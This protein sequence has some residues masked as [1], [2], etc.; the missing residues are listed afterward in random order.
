[1]YTHQKSLYGKCPIAFLIPSLFLHVLEKSL[2]SIDKIIKESPSYEPVHVNEH[3]PNDAKHRYQF[4]Q[5]LK[6][7]LSIPVV[8]LMHVQIW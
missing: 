8:H 7:G 6:G 4:L 1:M 2:E 3:C 5:A